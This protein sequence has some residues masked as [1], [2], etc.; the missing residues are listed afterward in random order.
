M[1]VWQGIGT[2]HEDG[3]GDGKDGRWGFERLKA[4]IKEME[5]E[6]DLVM[7]YVCQT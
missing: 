4:L 2:A 6:I 3:D 1:G 5:M 7:V